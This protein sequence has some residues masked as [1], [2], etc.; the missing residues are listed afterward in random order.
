MPE[1]APLHDTL[2]IEPVGRS[3]LAGRMELGASVVGSGE[4]TIEHD[5]MVVKRRGPGR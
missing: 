5:E 3:E 2:K 4:H 1:H